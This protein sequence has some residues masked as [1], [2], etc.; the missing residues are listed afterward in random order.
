M[1]DQ[2][3]RLE[4]VPR[5]ARTLQVEGA[6]VISDNMD[7]RLPSRI[8]SL[9]A[10]GQPTMTLR[11]AGMRFPYR[12]D[13]SCILF[14]EFGR[15]DSIINTSSYRMHACSV[16]LVPS[17]AVLHSIEYQAGTRFMIIAW[18]SAQLF[19]TMNSRSAHILR[20]AMVAPLHMPIS[21]ESMGRYVQLLRITVHVASGGPEYYFR[22]DIIGGFAEMLS[23]GLAKMI[24]EHQQAP[25]HSSRERYIL[26]RFLDM[27]RKNC[28]EHR[29]L[30]FYSESL[31]ISPKY[32]SRIVSKVSGRRAV[33]LIREN[34]ISEAQ[35]L[36]S[37]GELNV[38]QVSNMLNF[39]NA[40]YF[41]RYYLK[42]TGETPLTFQRRRQ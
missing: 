2:I 31:H 14:V 21:R 39:P 17:G 37:Q 11:P 41:G 23:G 8:A 42:A 20:R 24:L 34:V 32:L 35:L 5:M 19:A 10:A 33:D 1:D 40:S 13:F 9:L 15:V 36:L 4:M 16:L 29:D 28:R 27:V 38:Q 6:F 7:I 26:D 25:E 18:N 3:F 22:E 12:L 30:P